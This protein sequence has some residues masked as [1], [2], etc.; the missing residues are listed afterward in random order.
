M[1]R[2][3][4]QGWGKGAAVA[5]LLLAMAG[6][7]WWTTAQMGLLLVPA[8]VLSG[9]CLAG[10][11]LM[12]S[13]YPLRTGHWAAAVMAA[14]Q[15]VA[16][17][18]LGGVVVS[19]LAVLA[20]LVLPVP[21][22]ARVFQGDAA[23]DVVVF[24]LVGLALWVSARSVSRYTEQRQRLMEASLQ[25]QKAR[26]EAAE[27]ERE[28]AQSQLMLLRAQVEPHFLWNTLAHVQ[29]LIRKSPD[30]AGRMTGHLIQYLRAAVPQIR[31]DASTLGAEMASVSA[32]L[33]LM[34]IRMGDRLTVK[35][36]LAPT[37]ETLPF[38]PLLIQT[39]VENAIKHGVEP[40][41]GAVCVSVRTE[42]EHADGTR[43]V[44]TV[45]DDGVGLQTAPATRGTGMGL[46]GV[47]ERLK[48]LYGEGAVLTVTSAPGGG[49]IARM[50]VP[51]AWQGG[52]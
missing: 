43:L 7:E 48:L 27:R 14:L 10:L 8:G 52:V 5:L 38:A 34:Q 47:R 45:Q 36:A 23:T 24:T 9:V 4:S 25:A 32:Y 13:L 16:E 17:L 46:R 22:S 44:V 21:V 15:A 18:A 28:L 29:H 42:I 2:M 33:A 51:M 6:M 1:G 3:S 19:A 12:L 26:S 31:G 49:V 20:V 41:V 50:S 37:L 39:L 35:V 40:K 11:L 30:E